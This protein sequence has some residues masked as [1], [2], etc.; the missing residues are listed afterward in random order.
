MIGFGYLAQV[1]VLE[2]SLLVQWA[3][4]RV[5]NSDLGW[6]LKTP[7]WRVFLYGVKGG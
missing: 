1:V 4:V 2:S 7:A 5:I 6:I 3:Q